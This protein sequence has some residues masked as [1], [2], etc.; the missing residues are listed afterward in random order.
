[1]GQWKRRTLVEEADLIPTARL[2]WKA[3]LR[4][5][6]WNPAVGSALA[7]ALGL[8]LTNSL[9]RTSGSTPL[10][11]RVVE[12]IVPFVTGLQAA[13]LLSPEDEAPLELLLSCPRPLALVLLD[14]LVM[15]MILQG[16]VALTG[17]LVVLLMHGDEDWLMTIAR[18]FA[19]CFCLSGVALFT[20]QLT[21]Q[22]SFGALL[23][24]LMWGGILFGGDGLLRRWPFLWPLHVFLQPDRVDPMVYM[25]NRAALI[26]IGAI[27]VV[28]A[29]HLCRDEERVMIGHA[30]DV[31]TT[32]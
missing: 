27:L 5:V 15:L 17:N 1:M 11:L 8:S 23:E 12:T 25:L 18:W 28:L 31:K 14:R 30:G 24:T 7:V 21:R 4:L 16:S 10:T 32:L 2:T 6:G 22:G 29:L 26:T 19:P 3:N 13:F 20:S 9:W